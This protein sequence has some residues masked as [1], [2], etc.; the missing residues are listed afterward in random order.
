MR[1]TEEEKQ[2]LLQI[3]RDSIKEEFEQSVVSLNRDFSEALQQKCGVF[4]TLTIDGELRGCIGYIVGDKPLY[5]LVYEV[6][7]K[8]AFED[9]RFYSLT[10]EEVE[11]IVI[12][13]SVLTP[14]KRIKS[15]DEIRV[16][17]HGLIIR[18]GPFHGLLL[19][20]VAVKYNWTVKEFLEHTC[21]KAGLS[22]T[23][24]KDSQTI[25]E[26]FSAEVFSENEI[27]GKKDVNE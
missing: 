8:S 14:P 16:G 25:I 1:L 3:A 17:E 13:I 20:Q 10:K 7:K 24:W 23:E 6:A 22:K 5:E 4:V 18:K 26:I 11:H 15:I 2:T 9:P 19:P 12:E 21:L 27:G